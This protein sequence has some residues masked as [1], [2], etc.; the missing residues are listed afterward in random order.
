M[1][2]REREIG[3]VLPKKVFGRE[4]M[5]DVGGLVCDVGVGN[6]PHPRPLSHPPSPRLWG[7]GR[8]E[9]EEPSS[10]RPPSPR[11]EGGVVDSTDMMDGM[12]RR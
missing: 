7:T 6:F 8:V 12:D 3:F 1:L 9:G 11:G 5:F 2:S 4:P 10:S